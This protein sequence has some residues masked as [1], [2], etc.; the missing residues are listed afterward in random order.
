MDN[1]DT[2]LTGLPDD[3]HYAGFWIR[4]LAAVIDSILVAVIIVPLSL[5]VYGE[6]FWTNT[7]MVQG[8]ADVLISYVLP[9]AAAI[10]F[11]VYKSATPGKMMV[12]VSIVDASTGGKPSVGQ[13]I[14]RYLGYYISILPLLLGIFWV[15]FDKRKQ[16]WHDKL[17]GTAVV[18]NER[19]K[20]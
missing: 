8:W 12:K 10:L 13:C 4:V 17:A 19:D 16:G 18:Y 1:D 5:Q 15:G 6:D 3:T 7:D 20:D 14:G 11:W 2:P 9:A